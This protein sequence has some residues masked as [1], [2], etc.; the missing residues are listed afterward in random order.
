MKISGRHLLFLV[1]RYDP[2]PRFACHRVSW[3]NRLVSSKVRR[4]ALKHIQTQLGLPFL[5]IKPV[6]SKAMIRK[7]W[8]H[9]AIKRQLLVCVAGP[10]D[11][12]K[13]KDHAAAP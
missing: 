7:N 6:T 10:A 8:P 3:H 13:H 5:L 1:L 4:G 12:G 9:V 11:A 2:T